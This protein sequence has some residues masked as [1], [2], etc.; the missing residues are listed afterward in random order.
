MFGLAAAALLQFSPQNGISIDWPAVQRLRRPWQRPDL[1]VITLM[2]VLVFA[3]IWQGGDELYWLERLRIKL[4][5]LVIPLVFIMIPRFT[6]RELCLLLY[7]L[8]IWLTVNSIGISVNYWLHF[9]AI[10]AAMLQGQPMPTPGNHIRFS[11]LLAYGM[12][13]G[14]YLISQQFYYRYRWERPVIIS[15]TIFLFL[16]SHL[17]SVRSGL[18][19][20]Y[21]MLGVMA[22]YLAFRI[23]RYWIGLAVITLLVCMPLAGYYYLPSFRAKIQYMLYDRWMYERGQGGLYADSGRI[24]SLQVGYDIWKAHPIVGVGPGNFRAIVHERFTRQYPQRPHA[25]MPHNQ[26]LYVLAAQGVIGLL[27]FSVA[28]LYPLLYRRHYRQP[29]L[30]AFYLIFIGINMLEHHLENSVG[31]AS[32]V[33]LLCLCLKSIPEKEL[34]AQIPTTGSD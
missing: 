11:V 23:Q 26:F 29:H 5:L 17:L 3:G 2:F 16:F 7:F 6:R 32:F 34:G 31:I 4:P 33:I 15:M 22:I 30:L 19:V 14:G 10:Q 12:I 13:S 1:A 25:L 24:A 27:I 20:T 18:V 28:F 21:I 9:D 8:L